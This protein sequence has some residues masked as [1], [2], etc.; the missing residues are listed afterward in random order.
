MI[1]TYLIPILAVAGAGFAIFSVVSAARPLPV[2][3]PVVPPARPPFDAVIAGAGLVE[4]SSR[5]L[6]IGAPVSRLVTEL[7]ADVGTR[8]QAGDPL[9]RL[10]DR[11][12]RADL[13][14]RRA[15]LAA[16]KAQLER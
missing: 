4:A 10:D 9:F 6:A 7:V 1:R 15:A 3:S 14:V 2:A 16:A 12:V 11:D 13:D 5:N 8:V